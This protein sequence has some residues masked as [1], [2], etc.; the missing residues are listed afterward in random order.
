MHSELLEPSPAYFQDD[1]LPGI[2]RDVDANLQLDID[3]E[4]SLA[5]S[6]E[7]PKASCMHGTGDAD[8]THG[9][10]GVEPRQCASTTRLAT[11]FQGVRADS[12]DRHLQQVKLI[13]ERGPEARKVR[14]PYVHS[15]TGYGEKITLKVLQVSISA[16]LCVPAIPVMA[17]ET[18]ERRHRG[19]RRLLDGEPETPVKCQRVSTVTEPLKW[20]ATQAEVLLDQ[21]VSDS[22]PLVGR[23]KECDVLDDFLKSC[24]GGQ[25]G[26]RQPGPGQGSCLYLSGGPGTGKTS[27]ARGAARAWRAQFPSTRVVEINCMEQ[28]QPS[29]VAGFYLRLIEVCNLATGSVARPSVT[30]KSPLD[31]LMSAAA[32]SLQRLGSP[33]ILIIDEVDQLVKK[34]SQCGE[35]SLDNLC[36]LV[37]QPEA[38]AL[39]ILMIANAVDLLIRACKQGQEKCASLLFEPYSAEQLRSIVKAQFAAA[40]EEGQLAEKAL[41]RAGIE[42]SIRRV[43]KHSGDCRHIVRLCEDGFA[44]AARQKEAEGGAQDT[45]KRVLQ[46]DNDPLAEVKHFPT[47][48]QI[49]LGTLSQS[50]KQDVTFTD[51]FQRYKA[52]LSRLKQPAASK[53][54]ANAAISA[55]EQRGLLHLR[56]RRAAKGGNPDQVVELVVSRKS[57]QEVLCEASPL[58]KHC[59]S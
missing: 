54:Q 38:P 59:F 39:A 5:P 57:L 46:S 56:K 4:E 31:S 14:V 42:L 6:R 8:D 49:L 12:A 35:N 18:P 3:S 43:A 21:G 32:S 24:F 53:P 2:I 40:G 41:G 16:F 28:L 48:H 20:K 33:V 45:K 34:P 50:E 44:E 58:L 51:L 7:V 10:W 36:N 37:L 47:G 29:S 25:P 19:K 30:A 17:Y 52:M 26:Q 27:S 15:S 55:M 22:Y 23:D 1:A 11:S 9:S 13:W